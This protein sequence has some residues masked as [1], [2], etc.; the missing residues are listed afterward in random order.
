MERVMN[1]ILTGSEN[2]KC[3]DTQNLRAETGY[4]TMDPGFGNTGSCYSSITYVDGAKGILR[5]RGYPIEEL[6]EK[7][8]FIETA[9]LILYGELPTRISFNLFRTESKEHAPLHTNLEHHFSGFPKSAPP[10][11]ILSAML[12][13]V[14]CFHPEVLEVP[15]TGEEFDRTAALLLSKV[16][17]HCRLCLSDGRPANQSIIPIPIL[18]TAAIFCI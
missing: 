15:T 1:L 13:L 7:A 6:A 4:I 17:N 2:E 3:I 5:Y 18:P 12:N 8:I 16:T 10:M 11:A 9:Y 14:A